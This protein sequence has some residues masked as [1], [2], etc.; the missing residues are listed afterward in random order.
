VIRTSFITIIAAYALRRLFIDLCHCT[1]CAG[2]AT[3][4]E[5]IAIGEQGHCAAI[6]DEG[7]RNVRVYRPYS[8][9]GIVNFALKR[10]TAGDENL[11][12]WQEHR[13]GTGACEMQVA[14]LGPLLG[15]GVKQ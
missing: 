6:M 10:A 8:G 13:T 12:V 3:S 2:S 4:H 7:K 14:G 1:F 15:C 11:A 9:D 5:H